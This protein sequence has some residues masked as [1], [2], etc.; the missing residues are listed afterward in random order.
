MKK[1]D[2]DKDSAAVAYEKLKNEI[3]RDQVDQIFRDHPDDHIAK[4]E[5]IGFTYYDDD[6]D[7]DEELEEQNAVA[8]NQR[9]HDLVAYFEGEKDLSDKILAAY[10]GEKAEENPN[11]PLIRRYYRSANPNLKA[12]LLY[13]L[14]QYPNR[15]D[16]LDDLAFSHEFEKILGILIDRYTSACEQVENMET[17]SELA[18]GFYYATARDGY[19]ALYALQELFAPGTDKR[20][21]IDFMIAEAAAEKDTSGSIDF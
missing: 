14:D 13:G 16:L 18:R 19:E 7:D 1:K 11:Y 6:E 10:L 21:I 12:L 3:I 15:I 9:Q 5:E 2:K 20:K 4:L 8:E 17:F